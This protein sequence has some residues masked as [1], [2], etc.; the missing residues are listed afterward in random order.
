M[1]KTL[2]AKDKLEQCITE[3]IAP[4]G[5]T[6]KL[7][8]DF[9]YYY[10][11]DLVT[12]SLFT[13]D[14]VNDFMLDAESRFPKVFGIS[15]FMWALF[16]EV[17]HHETGDDLTDEE[18]ELSKQIKESINSEDPNSR[19]LYF[20]CPDE[21]AATEWAG[22]FIEEHLAEV[23]EMWNKIAYALGKFYQANDIVDE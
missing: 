11:K 22:C 8:T 23:E 5:L 19:L 1:G 6:A 4:F 7:D 12:F 14:C 3:C 21:Y 2:I 16:H 15:P 13:F 9:A 20:T 18:I 17:G 10:M